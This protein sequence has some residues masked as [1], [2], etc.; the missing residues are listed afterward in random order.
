ML[1]FNNNKKDKK[2][3][4]NLEYNLNTFEV[5]LEP[6]QTVKYLK[7][8]TSKIFNPLNFIP[9]LFYGNKDITEDE[10]AIIGDIFKNNL[11]NIILV[12]VQAP[13]GYKEK[14]TNQNNISQSNFNNF[15]NS[16]PKG[17]VFKLIDTTYNGKIKN[18]GSIASSTTVSS[19]S[20]YN[21]KSFCKC[22]R[23][24][25]FYYCFGCSDYFCNTCI[26]DHLYHKY[27]KI[28]LNNIGESIKIYSM[29]LQSELS[30]TFQKMKECVNAIKNQV[31]IDRQSRK[32]MILRKL[33]DIE[34]IYEEKI[35]K[36]E[37]LNL[38][39]TC[40]N[41]ESN[42]KMVNQEIEKIIDELSY[43]IINTKRNLNKLKAKEYLDFIQSK[44]RVIQTINDH[45][46]MY[47]DY[48]DN[49][50]RVDDMFTNIED[51][52]DK[53]NSE[54]N[55]LNK[56]RNS[57]FLTRK[58]P[59]TNI[60][61]L[62]ISYTSSICN[63]INK[64]YDPILNLKNNKEEKIYI[65]ARDKLL[66]PQTEDS[67]LQILKKDLSKYDI[68]TGQS[69]ITPIK[70][71]ILDVTSRSGSVTSLP[72]NKISAFYK[73]YSCLKDRDKENTIETVSRPFVSTTTI[74]E[75]PNLT[76]SLEI[77][78]LGTYFNNAKH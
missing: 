36:I 66:S 78:L 42:T 33:N 22:G 27:I 17:T 49:C 32:E 50:K 12:K 47:S 24:E 61:P 3:K 18:A 53:V 34:I 67:R 56:K 59:K 55:M 28:D 31:F 51:T 11:T 54:L 1:L 35:V 77:N 8:L 75:R 41:V 14:K 30:R 10:S 7:E 70:N 5:N 65:Q 71:R 58:M 64:E 60:N 2:L 76:R 63:S 73:E 25:F 15:N 40:E 21:D 4:I 9:K 26:N 20:I 19:N 43:N 57:T 68:F 52:I 44:D 37:S 16:K 48:Y 29:T 23:G 39:K 69:S 62:T 74:K 72:P 46:I 13:D 38:D 45:V 6:Y